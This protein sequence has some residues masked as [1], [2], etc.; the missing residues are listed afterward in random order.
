VPAATSSKPKP[1]P[2]AR[3]RTTVC[4]GSLHSLRLTLLGPHLG[5][6]RIMIKCLA[7]YWA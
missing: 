6:A 5:S 2:G 3:L 7:R 4:P 1:N